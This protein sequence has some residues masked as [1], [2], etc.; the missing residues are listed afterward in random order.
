VFRNAL[1]WE[2]IVGRMQEQR[3]HGI[4]LLL[5]AVGFL[6]TAGLHPMGPQ[7]TA[8]SAAIEHFSLMN[9]AVHGIALGS[10]WLSLFGVVGLS[11]A[12]GFQRPDVTAALTAF[13]IGAVMVTF[14]GIMEGLVASE[15]ARRLVGADDA[16]RQDVVQLMRYCFLIASSLTRFYVVAASA[17]IVL[18]STAM[19]RT[20][21]SR[22]LPWVGFF[23]ALLG[24]VGQFSGYLRMNT[25]D[26]MLMVV[27]QG[28]WIVWTGVV[29]IRRD[30]QRPISA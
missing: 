6:A 20:G 21:F 11:R 1:A 5:S 22:V 26:L 24:F 16:A 4:A 25:H 2:R 13:A 12:L 17:A 18:W 27:G 19:L 30:Q 8:S 10:I 9:K 3:I 7:V 15:L 23:I 14:A 29:M 28:V